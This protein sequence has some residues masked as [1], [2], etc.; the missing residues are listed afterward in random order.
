MSTAFEIKQAW[1][2]RVGQRVLSLIDDMGMNTVNFAEHFGELL[3]WDNAKAAKMALDTREKPDIYYVIQ[4]GVEF[5]IS[6]EYMFCLRDDLENCV[7]PHGRYYDKRA[8]NPEPKKH[9]ARQ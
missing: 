7:T 3:G 6:L 5:G 4:F 1:E 2:K 8:L 9:S